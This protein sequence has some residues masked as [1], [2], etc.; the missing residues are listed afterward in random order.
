MSGERKRN[1]GRRPQVTA[2]LLDSTKGA[3]CAVPTISDM[4][5]M[6]GTPSIPSVRAARWLLPTLQQLIEGLAEVKEAEFR[7]FR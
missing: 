6:V 5:R 4:T 7:E 1:D 2:P 3:L